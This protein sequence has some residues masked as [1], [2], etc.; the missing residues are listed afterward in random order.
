[1]VDTVDH[2]HGDT[3]VKPADGLNFQ[4]GDIPNPEE[5]D[6]FW[7]EVPSAINNHASILDA[8]D[9]NADGVVDAAD[10][11]ATA[12]A[13]KGNDIDTDGDG[14]VNA[15]DEADISKETQRI[16][17]RTD[18]PSNPSDGRIVFRTDKA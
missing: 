8:I 17:T 13:V 15:A 6:W 11:A 4:D 16:E 9:A 14:K 2:T 7:N 5:F 12:D 1:M 18:Y 10:S 3:G